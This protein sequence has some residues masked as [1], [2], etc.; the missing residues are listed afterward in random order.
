MGPTSMM[1]CVKWHGVTTSQ[2]SYIG[3]VSR[4]HMK[5]ILHSFPDGRQREHVKFRIQLHVV[6]FMLDAL[7]SL[8]SHLQ[9]YLTSI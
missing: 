2:A 9:V 8:A 3:T 7:L 5:L 1:P 4:Q 6:T